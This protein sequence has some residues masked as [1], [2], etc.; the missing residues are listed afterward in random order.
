MKGERDSTVCVHFCLFVFAMLW[1]ICALGSYICGSERKE[2]RKATLSIM[3]HLVIS[4]RLGIML[5]MCP[6]EMWCFAEELRIFRNWSSAVLQEEGNPSTAKDSS[7]SRV[8]ES[9][10]VR[11]F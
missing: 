1:R 3:S 7:A 5:G 8:Y 9:H 10:G 2:E 11:L 6:W 4:M